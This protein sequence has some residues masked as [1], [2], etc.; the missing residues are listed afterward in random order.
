MFVNSEEHATVFGTEKEAQN[1]CSF[2]RD[3]AGHVDWYL[4]G[5]TPQR[6]GYVIRAVQKTTCR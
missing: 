1:F 2:V 4:D 6:Q 5:P 3:R